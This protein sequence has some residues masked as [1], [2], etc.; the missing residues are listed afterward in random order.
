MFNG[1]SKLNK[2]SIIAKD[3]SIFDNYDY[4]I[5]KKINNYLLKKF[6]LIIFI[7]Q[8]LKI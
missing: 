7:P 2:N 3:E 1:Y 8:I 4:S 6:I 5:L